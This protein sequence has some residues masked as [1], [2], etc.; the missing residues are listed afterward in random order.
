[1]IIGVG[2]QNAK[3]ELREFVE[4]AKIPVIH[5]LPTIIPDDHPYSI[6]N[7]GKI[8]TKH[9]TKQFKMPIY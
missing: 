8:G 7:L 4:A 2:A 5:T 1:M 6:G 3:D 9:L